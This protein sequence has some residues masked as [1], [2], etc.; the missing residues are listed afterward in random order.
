[1][2]AMLSSVNW[3]LLLSNSNNI[4]QCCYSFYDILHY[5]IAIFVPTKNLTILSHRKKVL[6][7]L[8]V[9]R[10]R[11]K[12]LTLWR[13]LSKKPNNSHIKF[14]FKRAAKVLKSVIIK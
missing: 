14:K 7:P 9:K 8:S 5:A 10:L 1:M 12:K 11:P 3:Y 2:L 4:Q 13:L 6:L